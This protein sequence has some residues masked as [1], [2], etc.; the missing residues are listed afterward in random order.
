MYD[1]HLLHIQDSLIRKCLFGKDLNEHAFKYLE[2]FWNEYND[3]K[4]MFL[5][6]TLEGHEPTGQLIGYFDD[7]L[8]GFLNNFYNKGYFNNTAIIIFSDHGQHLTGPLYLLDSYDFHYEKIIYMI[9]FHQINK[10]L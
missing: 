3:Q 5:F 6:Q 7:V 4:K 1:G 9:I 10:L 8:F 2:S